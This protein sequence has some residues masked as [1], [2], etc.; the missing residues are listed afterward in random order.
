M[1]LQ[2]IRE[3]NKN[4]NIYPNMCT[5][6]PDSAAG[7]EVEELKSSQPVEFACSRNSQHLWGDSAVQPES[8]RLKLGNPS[9]IQ[10]NPVKEPK[11]QRF[12]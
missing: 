5:K 9:T 8:R 12:E 1:L 4:E 11:Q 6:P 3:V 10:Q 7:N 2:K